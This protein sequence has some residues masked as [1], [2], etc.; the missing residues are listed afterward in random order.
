MEDSFHHTSKWDNEQP[1]CSHEKK[2]KMMKKMICKRR[3]YTYTMLDSAQDKQTLQNEKPKIYTHPLSLSLSIASSVCTDE[4]ILFV[5]ES[6]I[7]RSVVQNP[8][9]KHD[10]QLSRKC[11]WLLLFQLALFHSN[12][13]EYFFDLRPHSLHQIQHSTFNIQQKSKVHTHKH[14]T[15]L[16][17]PPLQLTLINLE[18]G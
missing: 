5:L 3:T 4:F 2:K 16:T 8:P 9:T 14:T 17:I 1:W 18:L 11:L 15:D 10:L 7:C 12:P 13:C 6:L